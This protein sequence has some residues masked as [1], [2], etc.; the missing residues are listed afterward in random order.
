MIGIEY[1]RAAGIVST[2][3]DKRFLRQS[4]TAVRN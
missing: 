1:S 3:I 2:S 4:K